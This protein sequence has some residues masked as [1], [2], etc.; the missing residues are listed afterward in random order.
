MASK[1]L[2]LH[3]IFLQFTYYEKTYFMEYGKWPQDTDF[4]MEHFI[5]FPIIPWSVHF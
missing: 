3:E 2:N 5:C 4:D 1:Y